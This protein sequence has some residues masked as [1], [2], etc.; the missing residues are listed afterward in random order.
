VLCS[1]HADT[2][3]RHAMAD[4]DHACF[5]AKPYHPNDLIDT[6]DAVI[7]RAREGRDVA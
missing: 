6:L 5:L 1:A 4:D 2:D 3:E 7:A